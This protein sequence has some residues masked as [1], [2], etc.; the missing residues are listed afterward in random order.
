[1]FPGKSWV[2]FQNA[3]LPQKIEQVP[4]GGIFDSD[5]QVTWEVRGTGRW[6]ILGQLG[7]AAG[8]PWH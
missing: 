3:A 4:I 2:S 5:I 8:T 1:M 7:V 6:L